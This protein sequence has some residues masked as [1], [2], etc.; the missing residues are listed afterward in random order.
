MKPSFAERVEPTT[1]DVRSLMLLFSEKEAEW[2][3]WSFRF[4]ALLAHRQLLDTAKSTDEAVGASKNT[5]LHN[6]WSQVREARRRTGG[7]ELRRSSSR[8]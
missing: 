3:D 6:F 5:A 4:K 2:E 1:N 7:L 8:D